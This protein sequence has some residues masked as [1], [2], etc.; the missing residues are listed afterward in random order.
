MKQISRLSLL[1]ALW[2]IAHRHQLAQYGFLSD[3][4]K[5]KY[6]WK[7]H[8]MHPSHSPGE[9]VSKRKS[10]K[11]NTK[12]PEMCVLCVSGSCHQLQ[13][14]RAV[15]LLWGLVETQP[16]LLQIVAGGVH[17]SKTVSL[18]RTDLME[19][20]ISEGRSFDRR[21]KNTAEKYFLKTV[22]L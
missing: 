11:Q 16:K 6:I 7:N 10:K 9:I 22:K 19:Y 8:F 18:K 4:T 13:L 14:H 3:E 5:M 21:G 12:P 20:Y 15:L 17:C 1:T 2:F